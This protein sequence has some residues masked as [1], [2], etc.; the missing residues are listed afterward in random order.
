MRPDGVTSFELMQTAWDRGGDPPK[1]HD[2]VARGRVKVRELI[3]NL[4]ECG[5]LALIGELAPVLQM[6]DVGAQRLDLS[7]LLALQFL[8]F[9]FVRFLLALQSPVEP[10]APPPSARAKRR[11]QR[12]R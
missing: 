5:I 10:T 4:G 6:A 7:I 9:E 3:P 1:A 12:T 8:Q 2:A 11:L